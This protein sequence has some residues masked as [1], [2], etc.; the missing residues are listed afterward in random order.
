M[1]LVIGGLILGGIVLWLLL[2][3]L[4][5]AP[6]SQASR[7][8]HDLSVFKDQLAEIDRDVERGQLT[9]DQAA[10]SRIEVQR[11][12]IAAGERAQK[13]R[14]E[15]PAAN[16]AMVA[17][18]A[19]VV[20]IGAAGTYL[21]L[22]SPN[23]PDRPFADR[24]DVR[25]SQATA[26]N[27]TDS[28]APSE[29]TQQASSLDIA[30]Q[31]LAD[32]L[33]NEPDDLQGWLLLASAYQNMD[34]SA[35]AASAYEKAYTL[36][37]ES[38][39]IAT[40][41]GESLVYLHGGEV[42]DTAKGLFE[43]TLS[44]APLAPKPRYYLAAAEAQRGAYPAAIRHWKTMLLASTPDAPWRDQV[45]KNIA[46]AAEQGGIDPDTV[47]VEPRMVELASVMA[48]Q[49]QEATPQSASPTTPAPVGAPSA[50]GPGPTAEDMAAAA[51][52]SAED[53]QEMI[54]SMVA[55]VEERVQENPDALEDWMKLG[56]VYGVLNRTTDAADA[57]GKAAA[58]QPNDP[59]IAQLYEQALWTA[60]QTEQIA[61]RP[62]TAKTYWE[63]L[64][65]RLTPGS[66]S[67]NRVEQ[68]L[69]RL[70]S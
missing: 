7:S 64:L 4:L 55:R 67:Y 61:G 1:T 41:Y 6:T 42:S 8:D 56:R 68:A 17:V 38:P 29:Q 37:G 70:S 18:I 43:K 51:D 59:Q 40:D 36:S 66:E 48:G 21:Y 69:A 58:L 25:Q 9:E 26:A 60:G 33:K 12:I 31:K 46:M 52:M 3:G 2:K 22:G 13:S 63:T 20:P 24:T 54:L 44:V 65:G 15:S 14:R 10:A 50:A 45:N 19:L 28:Q 16:I 30:T 57:Y 5:F 27:A 32:R 47:A 11:R 39:E 35:D 23:K 34:R 53:R 49:R 62:D